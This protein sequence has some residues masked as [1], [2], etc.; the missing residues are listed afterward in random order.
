MATSKK[1][2]SKIPPRHIALFRFLKWR[3]WLPF[4]QGT[5]K[6]PNEFAR[7]ARRDG[8]AEVLF[9][10]VLFGCFGFFF[11]KAFWKIAL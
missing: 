1:A 8:G 10:S 2:F 6:L 7:F 5:R 4:F 3:W 9:D 11:V